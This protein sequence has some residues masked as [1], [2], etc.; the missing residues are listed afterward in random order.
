MFVS[1]SRNK[2]GRDICVKLEYVNESSVNTCRI[3]SEYFCESDAK[4]RAKSKVRSAGVV[5]KPF[6]HKA[7]K[8]NKPV[9]DNASS[10][11]IAHENIPETC[12]VISIDK[13]RLHD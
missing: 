1:G 9:S 10:E 12:P 3:L 4:E 13:E 11:G 8:I 7:D 6:K 2:T 5:S